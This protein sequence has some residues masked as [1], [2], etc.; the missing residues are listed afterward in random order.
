MKELTLLE[1]FA[2]PDIMP[3][4]PM[5]DKLLA[6]L[7]VTILG[8]GVTFTALVILWGLVA[9]MTKLVNKP[10]PKE[11]TPTVVS[12]PIPAQAVESVAE[13][14]QE[15]EELVAVITAAIAAT[16]QTSTHNIL[17]RNIVRLPDPTPSWGRMGRLEQM[18]S[19][20]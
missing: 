4:L 7:Y 3:G 20:F 8:M 5:S 17:V 14:A 1:K 11:A 2:N 12:T 19:R 9:L 16:L 13:T 15:D 18:N 6:S 10:S